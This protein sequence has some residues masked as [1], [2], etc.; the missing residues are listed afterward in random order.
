VIGRKAVIGKGVAA[1]ETVVTDG[2]LLLF[3]G[4][5]IQPVAAGKVDNLTL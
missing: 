2:Q 1:G 5:K 3:P 4:A